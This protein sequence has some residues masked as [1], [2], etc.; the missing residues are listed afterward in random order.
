M[1]N[2]KAEEIRRNITQ[3]GFHAYFVHGRSV[4]SFAYTIGLSEACGFEVCF[5]GLSLYSR[6]DV[7]IILKMV[8]DILRNGH[9]WNE[10]S[11]Q[12]GTI[13]DFHLS[14]IDDSWLDVM[15][16]G[17]RDF[18]PS[19]APPC[20]QIRPEHENITIDMPDMSVPWNA[21]KQPIWK[22]LTRTWDYSVPKDSRAVTDVSSLKGALNTEVMRWEVDEWELHSIPGDRLHDD[23]IR[24]VPLG[25]ML[26]WDSSLEII[27]D[28]TVGEGFWRDGGSGMWH[29]WKKKGDE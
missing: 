20:L 6:A 8:V 16:L 28:L 11:V 5:A 27:T 9:S 17:I 26:G 24:V 29:S 1:N 25:I 19:T 3:H 18:F 7:E 12:V 23:D 4:P 13:G 15:L 10:A 2:A 21:D 14:G 22:W